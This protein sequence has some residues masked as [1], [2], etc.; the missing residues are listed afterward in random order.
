[1]TG[2]TLFERF[3]QETVKDARA[4]SLSVSFQH[5]TQISGPT[6]SAKNIDGREESQEM[7]SDSL[8]VRIFNS[9]NVTDS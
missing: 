7:R 2:G 4:M 8:R 1:M 9:F 3:G 5:A 6:K